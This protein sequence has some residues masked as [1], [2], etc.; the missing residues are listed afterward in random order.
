[1]KKLSLIM[2]VLMIMLSQLWDLQ[3]LK[4]HIGKKTKK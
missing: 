4:K 2:A 1:M 3:A